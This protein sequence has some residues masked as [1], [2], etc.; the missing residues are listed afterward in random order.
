MEYAGSMPFHVIFGDYQDLG[1]EARKSWYLPA[2]NSERGYLLGG[3]YDVDG[4]KSGR[5][6]RGTMMMSHT[7]QPAAD[8]AK[9][10]GENETPYDVS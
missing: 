8:A 6:R 3:E 4:T 7:T 10:G 1:F 5:E 2:I 9:G